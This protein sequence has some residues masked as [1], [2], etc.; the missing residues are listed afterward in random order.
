MFFVRLR[1][2]WCQKS[3]RGVSGILL[4]TQN[5]QPLLLLIGQVKLIQKPLERDSVVVLRDRLY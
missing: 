2:K 1:A 4:L 5:H 3:W